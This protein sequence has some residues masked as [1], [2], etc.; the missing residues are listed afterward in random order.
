MTTYYI[1]LPDFTLPTDGSEA[2]LPAGGTI[3]HDDGLLPKS[4]AQDAG[5]RLIFLAGQPAPTR[6]PQ[7]TAA[8]R[9][10]AAKVGETLS[11]TTNASAGAAFQWFRDNAPIDGATTATLDTSGQGEGRYICEVSDGRQSVITDAAEVTAAAGFS[12]ILNLGAGRGL[13]TDTPGLPTGAIGNGPENGLWFSTV[14]YHDGRNSGGTWLSWADNRSST[15]YLAWAKTDTF[16]ARD[17]SIASRTPGSEP[18]PAAGWYVLTSHLFR[19]DG[20]NAQISVW[21]NGAKILEKAVPVS[22][23]AANIGRMNRLG[24]GYLARSAADHTASFPIA[25]LA[26][27]TGD[28]ETYHANIWNGG[29]WADPEHAGLGSAAK[30][31]S[32]LLLRTDQPGFDAGA[33]LTTLTGLH[34]SGHAWTALPATL[35]FS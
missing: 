26:W 15:Y 7:L 27:G 1:D 33:Q 13:Y 32:E 30:A 5:S 18:L 11:L 10:S 23:S 17:G 4:W 3:R 14:L 25:H 8:I 28:P 19:I 24:A 6:I 12:H 9:Q 20:S 22:L 16:G 31:G 2:V 29:N 21:R 35:P 34:G